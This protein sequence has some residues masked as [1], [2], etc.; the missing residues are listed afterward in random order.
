MESLELEDMEHGRMVMVLALLAAVVAI[1]VGLMV[2]ILV[3]D[4]LVEAVDHPLY[5]VI[6]DVMR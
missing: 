2:F 4:G 6:Q 1:M 5:L 3:V